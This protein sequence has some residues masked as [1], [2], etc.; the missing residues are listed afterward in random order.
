[1]LFLIWWALSMWLKIPSLPSL[2]FNSC[3]RCLSAMEPGGAQWHMVPAHLDCFWPWSGVV[4]CTTPWCQK[5]AKR[6]IATASRAKQG[7]AKPPCIMSGNNVYMS[8]GC[9][10]LRTSEVLQLN[11]LWLKNQLKQ[12]VCITRV[13]FYRYML[14]KLLCCESFFRRSAHFH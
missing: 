4:Y 13:F 5:Q 1:M 11:F 12:Q 2:F 10:N 9:K 6:Y 14:W 3:M 8:R 7:A